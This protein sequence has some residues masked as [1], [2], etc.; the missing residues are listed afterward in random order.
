[1]N[2]RHLLQA[3]VFAS[4]MFAA[5]QSQSSAAKPAVPAL[6]PLPTD[7]NLYVRQ[8][9]Q[10]ELDEQEHDHRL[11]RFRIH[12]E[13]RN[14]KDDTPYSYDRDVIQTSEGEV[15]RPVLWNGQPVPLR[16]EY[17]KRMRQHFADQADRTKHVKRE[18]TDEDKVRKLFGAAP[19]AFNFQYEGEEEGLV[20]LRFAPKPHYDA[21]T[22]ELRIFRSLSG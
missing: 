16:P 11:W 22:R 3:V 21:P 20:R 19:D 6:P 2:T 14:K 5:A 4:A 9:I 12:K 13:G 10:H 15:S 7:A 17:E 8:V 18:K 1:M